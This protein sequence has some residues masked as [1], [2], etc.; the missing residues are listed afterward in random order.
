M[1]RKIRSISLDV[2]DYTDK[3]LCNLFN[4][5][6]DLDGGAHDVIVHTERN[7]YKE[8]RFSMP[9][10]LQ[11]GEPN[12]RMGYLISDYR[13]KLQIMRPDEVEVDWFLISE[14]R[15]THD[16][17]SEDYE[18]K[19]NHISSLLNTKNL[20]LEFSDEEGNNVGTIGQIAETI[21]EG[22]GWHLGNVSHFYEDTKYGYDAEKEKVRS[23]TASSQ[24]GAFKMISD[25][26][27]LFDA[28]PL[29]HGRGKYIENGEEK[30]GRTVDI[31]PMNP[32]SEDLEE[33]AI[34]EEVLKG[35]SVLELYYDRNVTNVSRTLNTDNIVTKLSAYGSYGDRNG[36]CSLQEATHSV[37]TFN[38]HVGVGTYGFE[39]QNS[40]FFFTS[41]ADTDD[42]Q[43]STL[44][45]A[46][47]S[48]VYD[49]V[50]LYRIFKDPPQSYTTLTTTE[51]IVKNYVP[52]LMDFT[53]YDKVGLLSDDMLRVLAEHQT[54][55]PA[56][57][58]AATEASIALSAEKEKL[59]KTASAGNGFLMLDI[60]DS[61]TKNGY[62]T[63]NL[64]TSTYP[65]GIIYRSD[66][67]EAVR[68]YFSWFT[69]SGL[70]T[71]GEAIAGKGGV[72][73]IVHEGNPTKWD[74]CYIKALGNGTD[75]YY[76]D[77]LGNNYKL[78][79]EQHYDHK[80]A[81]DAVDAETYFPAIGQ[82]NIIYCAD[83]TEKMYVWFN[84]DYQ[85]LLAADYYFGIN[86]FEMP[87]TITLWTDK[88][89]WRNTDKVYLFSADSI[90]G[91]FG[92]REDEVYSNRKALEEEIKTVTE[93][94]PV[95]FIN[96]NESLPSV[97]ECLSG[98]GW[99]YKSYTNEFR[100]GDLYFCWGVNGDLGWSSVNV[101]RG[102]QN[103]ETMTPSVQNGYLYSTKRLM[104]YT[105]G[106]TWEPVK[107]TVDED[108]L[109]AAF[110]AVF[111]HCLNQEILTKGYKEEY[112]YNQSA[113]VPQGNY[114][115]AT[116]FDTYWLFTTRKNIIPNNGD[117]LKYVLDTKVMWQDNDDNN[118]IKPVECSFTSL[119]FPSENELYGV[120][121]SEGDYKNQAFSTGITYNISNNIYVHE[122]ATYEF[123][124]PND[125]IV[126][127]L[128]ANNIVTGE[129]T[130]S[131]FVAPG[132]TTHVRIVTTQEVT[133]A[134]RL[135]VQDYQNILFS[136]NKMYKILPHSSSGERHGL[137]YLMDQFIA[138]A[139]EAYL[140]KLPAL[141]E[142]QQAI[143]D[144]NILL[145]NTM[146]D[147]FREGCWRKEDYVE[148]DESKLYADTLDNLKEI[149]H[150]EATYDI[151]FLDL[152]GSQPLTEDEEETPWP[153]IEITYAAHLVDMDIDT[154]KW[155]YIDTLDKCYD[156]PWK[157][158][159]E[160]NTRL[161]MIG[162]QSFTDVLSKIAE[163]SNEA[164]A[165][166]TIYKR[167]SVLTNSGQLAADRLRGAIETNKTLIMS[168][169]SNW[170]TD[171]KGNIVFESADGNSAMMLS[172]KGWAISQS[173]DI[174]G[175]W[176]WRY[177][178]TGQGLTADSIY[179]G[180]LSA[181]RLEVGSITTDKLAANVGQEL[182]IGSNKALTL[183]ATVDGTRPAGTLLTQ[184]P[185][186]T[187]S[188]V[189]IGAQS[190]N[191][192]A[193]VDIQSGG[194]VN[195]FGG[196]EINIDTNGR[197][198][199]SGA[200]VN[201]T[202]DTQMTVTSGEINV[203]ST[204]T[205]LIDSDNFKIERDEVTGLYN[206]TIR[207][208]VNASGNSNIAGFNVGIANAGEQNEVNYL[209][210]GS[211]TSFSSN[212][213]GVYIGTDG[214][215][216]RGKF[217]V[218]D[219]GYLTSESG[220][221]G[222]WN[223]IN[224]KLY[225][226]SGANYVALSST[227]TDY[228]IWAGNETAAN[229]PFS[230]K[231]DGTL[232][233]SSG[234]VGNWYI[235]NTHIG[236][237]ATEENS[238]VGLKNNPNPENPDV[239]VLWAGNSTKSNANFTLTSGGSIKATSGTVGGWYI[240]TDYIGNASS[241][242]N[243][244]VG[245]AY[246]STNANNNNVFWAGGT[247]A[248]TGNN[249][250]KFSVD[251]NG[252]LTASGAEI[253]GDSTFSGTLSAN[254]INSGT[255]SATYISGGTLDASKMTVSN[256]SASS[257]TTGTMSA[258][259]ID[260]SR[261]TISNLSASVITT[262]TMSGER[263][264]T[265][266]LSA[267]K[268]SGGTLTLGGS[269]NGNGTLVIN[270]ASGAQIGGWNNSGISATAGTIG[271]WTISGTSTT[272][273]LS[274]GSGTTYV[275]LDAGSTSMDY[276]VWVGGDSPTG[277][278]PAPFRVKRDGS[279]YIT[280]LIIQDPDDPNRTKEIN[281]YTNF[282]D[283]TSIS[284]TATWSGGTYTVNVRRGS[285]VVD[286]W[287]TKPTLMVD[288]VARMSGYVTVRAKMLAEGDTSYSTDTRIDY[289]YTGYTQG[290]FTK[291]SMQFYTKTPYDTYSPYSGD[292]YVKS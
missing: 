130:T 170:Y 128:N 223:I 205:F 157:T 134:H 42:L 254:C 5:A 65:D 85:D 159:L 45:F 60:I 124:L 139:N 180:Y 143:T 281:L 51:S 148:G 192:P 213:K 152:Y 74:K 22:T 230:V 290:T 132:H 120:V 149:S 240:G 189:A 32:F 282:N 25:L 184:H 50:N 193:Y 38:E 174:D 202:A 247:Y 259:A 287:T 106:D 198:N 244:T 92:P 291:S 40:K 36:L 246:L 123:V 82:E 204:G 73:Y 270:N 102:D 197:L 104:L 144:A 211:T 64:K 238:T 86:E 252:K 58:L 49:G 206:V 200:I 140:V 133:S 126:V 265:G 137:N 66:Y 241:K 7:G 118:I 105:A 72:V 34:P 227:D 172:G 142:A 263:I 177:I 48:Y 99:C 37:L 115:F 225:S 35:E 8:L 243:S 274:S 176:D 119:E 61:G 156:L 88:R 69:A 233:A 249:A 279:V 155:A 78:H 16:A 89:T 179:T 97:N 90:A 71:N 70:K 216:L 125:A 63:L 275:A 250:P 283:A 231:K 219:E 103:P 273:R 285:K 91:L 114:A 27:E 151:T 46:S 111:K 212:A 145:G 23:F 116:E 3:A 56:K 24:S 158:T 196:S 131:P 96:D 101:Y 255:L 10:V 284:H 108:R 107:G 6:N 194:Q 110:A 26:C 30:Y 235:S 251:K 261:V 62:V 121:F 68:N 17:F 183:Y 226:G 245:M 2:C 262:G 208:G 178:A 266:T 267:S 272:K 286:S 59:M 39:W 207:G 190:G 201:L 186:P 1:Q 229:A 11:T 258:G 181:E 44:D 31:I 113:E 52:Y 14:S 234:K 28:K 236:N 95:Y 75:N 112:F 168:G 146:G 81:A 93:V 135:R 129:M 13:I 127:C 228:R 98:M 53:Y 188:W 217:K 29:Y 224:N 80:S 55:I 166:Q 209:Y 83:D 33:G 160:I 239:I 153:D 164:K 195:L 187:D 54:N 9:S 171:S 199:M 277:S 232:L 222:G 41:T 185:N 138:I 20:E 94:H 260:A 43:W 280:K 21:L 67:D 47:R 268:I 257:I 276:A 100:F 175:T 256:L 136:K 57:H 289:D 150:P 162:Q 19:A 4:S 278:T 292:L 214:I 269:G 79:V 264:T 218:T 242:D 210:A 77:S 154:N 161:S 109:T 15:I 248:G 141:K 18:I 117:Q 169:T 253:K 221:I 237:A 173:K 167:A 122:K 87:T 165:N 191:D 147:T 182:E 271:G 215:N 84:N 220:T 76:R 163:V 203:V 12:W 288:T